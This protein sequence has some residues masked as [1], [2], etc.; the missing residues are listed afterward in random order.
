MKRLLRSAGLEVVTFAS[1]RDFLDSDYRRENV[2]LIVDIQMP[3]LSGLDLKREL[4]KAG[5]TIPVIF[6]TAFDSA[7]V[8]Q[9]ARQVQAAGYFRKPVDD[10]ALLDA[11]DW[12]LSDS[13]E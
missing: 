7:A 4:L 1:A 11:I 3:D 12:A 2:C 9:Q 5:S 6:I 13:V 10:R 8:R